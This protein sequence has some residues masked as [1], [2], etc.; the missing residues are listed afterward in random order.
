MPHRRPELP[1]S[2]QTHK[3]FLGSS[4]EPCRRSKF[5]RAEAVRPSHPDLRMLQEVS[6][7]RTHPVLRLD[8]QGTSFPDRTGL[9]RYL[10]PLRALALC[11]QGHTALLPNSGRLRLALHSLQHSPQAGQQRQ[12]S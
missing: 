4:F 8:L 7:Q 9:P 5:G 2:W 3:I 6:L 10:Y 12:V 1:L 11:M